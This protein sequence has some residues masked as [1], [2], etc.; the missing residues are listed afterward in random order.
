MAKI[1][2]NQRVTC[3][4]KSKGYAWG[5]VKEFAQ[6]GEVAI[7]HLDTVQHAADKPLRVPT[8]DERVYNAL[9]GYCQ[10]A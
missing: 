6:N 10:P 7:L 9:I 1:E 5:T 3:L 2:L 4:F 8:S